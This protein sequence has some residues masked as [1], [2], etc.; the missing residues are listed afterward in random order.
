MLS[1][2][3]NSL[4]ALTILLMLSGVCVPIAK[5]STTLRNIPPTRHFA[6]AGT[7]PVD[8]AEAIKFAVS[9]QGWR[10]VAEAPGI[11]QASLHVRTH[12]AVVNIGF[13]ES[14]FWIEYQSSVNLDYNPNGRRKTR[15]ARMRA[16]KGP[17]IHRNYNIWVHD[18]ATRIAARMKVPPQANVSRSGPSDGL[19]LIADELE[20]LDALRE[21]GVLSQE[22]FDQQKARLLAH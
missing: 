7:A 15:T 6:P 1:G 18:L 2:T 10:V 5:A 3:R 16:V 11:I 8:L 14:N 22:E 12:D 17:R 9:E 19:I 4:V 13:D 21:R 20:K